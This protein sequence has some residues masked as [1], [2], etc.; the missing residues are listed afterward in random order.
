MMD[1]DINSTVI[2]L[3]G[4]KRC[5]TCEG[6]G[7]VKIYTGHMCPTCFGA[8]KFHGSWCFNCGG[9]GNVRTYVEQFCIAC[10]G[11]GKQK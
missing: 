3:M 1:D 4:K 5:S 8:G 11:S 10:N 9:T 6:T 2:I 7:K